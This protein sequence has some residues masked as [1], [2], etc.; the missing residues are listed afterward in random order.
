MYPQLLRTVLLFGLLLLVPSRLLSQESRAQQQ[1]VGHIS[2]QVRYAEGGQPAFNILIRCD[3]F[4]SGS[5]GQEMTDRSGR[6]RFDGLAPSQYIITV[7]AQGYVEQQ[8]TVELLTSAVA[9]IQ[10]QLRS[11]GSSRPAASSSV[12]VDANVPVAAKKEFEQAAALVATGKKESLNESVSHLEKAVTIYPQ[13]VEAHLMLGTAYLD[14]GQLEKAEPILKRTVELNPKAANAL[15]A[16]GGLYL[17]QKKDE[18]AEKALLQG[19]Q[20]EDRSTQGHLS[21][22]R[23]YW[24]MAS[25]IKDDTQARPALEKAYEQVKKSLELKPDFAQ[26]HLLKGNLLLRARRAV[27]AQHEFEEY[28]RLEPKGAFAEQARTTVE[29]IKKAMESQ[30][31]P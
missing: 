14:L 20:I 8:Q 28:L 27:D 10:F 15:F 22:A 26:A 17:K 29:K 16:L 3:A 24:S 6:F 2:G 7:R 30:P 13:F 21:L 31:K 9:N 1:P 18:D 12:V 25:K 23:V 19:L 4:N 11:D 5:C